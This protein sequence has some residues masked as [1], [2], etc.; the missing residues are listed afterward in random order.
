[1]IYLTAY[2]DCSTIERAKVTEPFGYILKPF[3]EQE[4]HTIVEIALRKHQLQP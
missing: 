2:A 3:E 4:L 1:M